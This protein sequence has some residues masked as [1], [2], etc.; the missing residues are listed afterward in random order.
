MIIKED[1]EIHKMNMHLRTH[2][3]M[4]LMLYLLIIYKY[5]DTT[6]RGHRL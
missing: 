5:K 4:N 6:K 2:I 3:I 1:V